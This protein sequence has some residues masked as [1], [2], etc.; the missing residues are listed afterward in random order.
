MTPHLADVH[1]F[2]KKFKLPVGARPAFPEQ[3]FLRMRINFLLE[4][5]AELA[6]ASGGEI[7]T[8]LLGRLSFFETN[9]QPDLREALDA[10][11]DLE[12]VLHGTTIAFGLHGV[13]DQA[14][15]RVQAANLQ[16]ILVESSDQSKRGSQF[17]VRKPA[18]WK[19]P[20]FNDLIDAH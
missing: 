20:D 15:D 4:E 6:I 7:R 9:K 14:W 8:D 18:G 5:L 2:I 17:D 19:A 10:L 1:V 13:Y 12:Y 11:V 3:S 16:K